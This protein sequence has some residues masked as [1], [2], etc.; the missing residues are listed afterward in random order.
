MVYFTQ[1]VSV[2]ALNFTTPTES[3]KYFGFVVLLFFNATNNIRTDVFADKVCDNNEKL[4][5]H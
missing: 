1:P 5:L 3:Y 2:A 4:E